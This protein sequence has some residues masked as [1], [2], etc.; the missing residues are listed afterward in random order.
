MARFPSRDDYRKYLVEECGYFLDEA[1][2]YIRQLPSPTV[3]RRHAQAR[4]ALGDAAAAR[5]LLELAD[6]IEAITQEN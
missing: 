4:A 5:V 2:D 6:V 1:E 3:V